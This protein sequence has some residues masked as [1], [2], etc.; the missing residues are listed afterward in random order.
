M[1]VRQNRAPTKSETETPD[2]RITVE[3]V[4]KRFYM[5]VHDRA[6]QGD[7]RAERLR[8]WL[9]SPESGRPGFAG[10]AWESNGRIDKAI[11]RAGMRVL[12]LSNKSEG[13]MGMQFVERSLGI[14]PAQVEILRK[15][16]PAAF[17]RL[18]SGPM[19]EGAN[20]MF[21]GTAFTAFISALETELARIDKAMIAYT[22]V[23][24][25]LEGASEKAAALDKA[26]DENPTER[27][28]RAAAVFRRK[29][30]EMR[31]A[32]NAAQKRMD[33]A[34]RSDVWLDILTMARW[35]LAWA[36]AA[37]L[38][39]RLIHGSEVREGDRSLYHALRDALFG[40]GRS[41]GVL[42]RTVR[43]RLL[44]PRAPG[45]TEREYSW[46][47]SLDTWAAENAEPLRGGA[48][49]NALAEWERSRWSYSEYDKDAVLL[50]NGRWQAPVAA[51]RGMLERLDT[52]T[53]LSV[54][55]FHAEGKHKYVPVLIG[56]P[57]TGERTEI[58][59][60]RVVVFGMHLFVSGN[61]TVAKT[62][63]RFSEHIP[64]AMRIVREQAQR[65]FPPL[66]GE[67]KPS[68]TVFNLAPEFDPPGGV[69]YRSG[70]TVTVFPHQY[71]T[72][73]AVAKTWVHEAGHHVWTEFLSP[74]KRQVWIDAVGQN[75]PYDLTILRDAMRAVQAQRGPREAV[76][77][78]DSAVYSW[79]KD[80]NGYLY[81][82]TQRLGSKYVYAPRDSSLG[83]WDSGD[84][85]SGLSRETTLE[86]V[87]AMIAAKEAAGEAPMI[88]FKGLPTTV[89]GATNVEE[90]WCEALSYYII[91]GP[92][93]V[94]PQLRA[95]MR[96]LLPDMRRNPDDEDDET[97]PEGRG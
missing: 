54:L 10:R 21:V 92:D 90:G 58:A 55:R 53:V 73:R 96:R 29:W 7:K 87:E 6:K 64:V 80:N 34:F 78:W 66:A 83:G 59:G 85:V 37:T 91:Y 69:Y 77:V 9:D 23:R 15:P 89:Y 4:R 65:Y 36:A 84:A 49:G 18:P 22:K 50:V 97:P 45:Q 2:T 44:N 81:V 19:G 42:N 3:D 47:E 74:A 95:A 41:E 56:R 26:A 79:L 63:A 33:T 32:H 93:A 24:D 39:G 20:G 11:T 75:A 1:N 71:D 16:I 31:A 51:L 46:S 8:A 35:V 62:Y 25:E 67:Y 14:K 86:E 82:L 88:Y 48:D 43:L 57:L 70:N 12:G 38:Y 72:P 68:Q 27:N 94:L 76:K 5:L 13:P 61:P 28:L 30:W 17:R 60:F 52:Q 40:A